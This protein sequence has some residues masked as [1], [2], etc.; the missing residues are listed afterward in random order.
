MNFLL[1]LYLRLTEIKRLNPGGTCVYLTSK[2]SSC[3]PLDALLR[4]RVIQMFQRAPSPVKPMSSQLRDA[5]GLR[6]CALGNKRRGERGKELLAQGKKGW[7]VAC[8]WWVGLRKRM[9]VSEWFERWTIFENVLGSEWV[10]TFCF[11][12]FWFEAYQ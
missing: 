2:P 6:L 5:R 4:R 12:R 9:K 3:V 1:N 11:Q 8:R 7:M 10:V